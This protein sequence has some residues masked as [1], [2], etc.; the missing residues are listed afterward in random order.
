MSNTMPLHVRTYGTSES[1]LI[2]TGH[3]GFGYFTNKHA[4]INTEI[5]HLVYSHGANLKQV[6]YTITGPFRAL[7]ISRDWLDSIPYIDEVATFFWAWRPH[8]VVQIPTASYSAVLPKLFTLVEQ[9]NVTADHDLRSIRLAS[10]GTLLLIIRQLIREALPFDQT[11]QPLRAVARFVELVEL[12]HKVRTTVQFY[13]DSIG[14]TEHYLG[15]LCRTHLELSAK[16]FIQRRRFTTA[17]H[18]LQYTGL[19]SKEIS[20]ELG[21]KDPNYFSRFFTAQGEGS[22][23]S[24]RRSV[25][26]Q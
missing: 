10:C 11:K 24:Y 14:V 16:E 20:F 8:S 15:E 9:S 6:P 12:E 5:S 18:L 22:P 17:K 23:S 21:F 4:D 13:A 3:I 7:V 26:N 19:S 25:R 1:L 2:P